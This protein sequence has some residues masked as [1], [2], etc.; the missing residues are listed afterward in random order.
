MF[1]LVEEGRLRGCGGALA[2]LLAAFW[3][4]IV[5]LG[6][7]T[8][9]RVTLAQDIKLIVIYLH[10]DSCV[11]KSGNAR[12]KCNAVT[13][14]NKEISEYIIRALQTRREI[15]IHFEKTGREYDVYSEFPDNIGG[16]KVYYYISSR[17]IPPLSAND[18]ESKSGRFAWTVH[19]VYGNWS[20]RRKWNSFPEAAADVV[21]GDRTTYSNAAGAMREFLEEIPKIRGFKTVFTACFTRRGNIEYFGELVE[22]IP[23]DLPDELYEKKKFQKMAR[24]LEGLKK[25]E[26]RDVMFSDEAKNICVD[27]NASGTSIRKY[28]LSKEDADYTVHGTIG[29]KFGEGYG[30]IVRIS[31]KKKPPQRRRALKIPVFGIPGQEGEPTTDTINRL[32]NHIVE[33]WPT[34]VHRKGR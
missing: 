10:G 29:K 24:E 1:G 3:I 15:K 28:E 21:Y 16:I 6:L 20:D 8:W 18:L 2:W 22:D 9:S 11:G 19:D 4:T 13:N 7:G 30:I 5:A 34:V 33:E 27:R 25:Y 23:V 26:M 17:F 14:F 31:A 32:A 12:T